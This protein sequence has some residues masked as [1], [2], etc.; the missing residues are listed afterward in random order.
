MQ[1]LVDGK[2]GQ[3]SVPDRDLRTAYRLLDDLSEPA[4]PELADAL[5]E[6]RGLVQAFEGRTI[7]AGWEVVLGS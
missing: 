3:M 7:A 5:Q 2:G 4:S 6:L 1:A